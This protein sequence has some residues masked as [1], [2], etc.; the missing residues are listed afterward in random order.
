M[1]LRVLG[2]LASSSRVYFACAAGLDCLVLN[3]AFQATCSGV[4]LDTLPLLPMPRLPLLHRKDN[5]GTYR[6]AFGRII[7]GCLAHIDDDDDDAGDDD[8]SL[9]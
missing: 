1:L 4:V 6:M 7:E 2:Y 9:F 5:N 8:N 3:P